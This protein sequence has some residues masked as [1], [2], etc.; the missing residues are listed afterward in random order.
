M[1]TTNLKNEKYILSEYIEFVGENKLKEALIA[2]YESIVPD[3]D[4]LYVN[5]V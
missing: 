1:N 2:T 3:L 5:H 4:D